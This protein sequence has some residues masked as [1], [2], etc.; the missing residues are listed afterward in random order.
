MGALFGPPLHSNP[1]IVPPQENTTMPA[2]TGTTT[3]EPTSPAT[4]P[5]GP[6]PGIPRN[7]SIEKMAQGWVISWLP[8]INRTVAVAYYRIEF[9]EG[10]GGGWQYS[11]PIAK[12]TAYLGFYILL[13]NIMTFIHIHLN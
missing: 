6:K 1:T 12:D 10:E 11:E 4:T 8:P 3:D 9:K 5:V 2:T 13:K 7:V